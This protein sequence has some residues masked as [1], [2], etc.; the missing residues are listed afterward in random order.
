M[1]D[2]YNVVWQFDDCLQAIQ[3]LHIDIDDMM[4][5]YQL[6]YVRY[7]RSF[8]IGFKLSCSTVI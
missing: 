6:E 5:I 1:R 3:V 2:L 8:H 7:L 4:N